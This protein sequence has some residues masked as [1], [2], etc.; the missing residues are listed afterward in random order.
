MKITFSP[1][2][3]ALKQF[4]LVVTCAPSLERCYVVEM[5]TQHALVNWGV[6]DPDGLEVV[7]RW[8]KMNWVW[9]L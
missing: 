8:Y 9:L 1:K 5:L 2:F 6:F 3:V 7:R 4:V